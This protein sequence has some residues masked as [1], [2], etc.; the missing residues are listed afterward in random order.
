[1]SVVKS[2]NTLYSNTQ[3]C[4]PQFETSFSRQEGFQLSTL[5]ATRSGTAIRPHC[6]TDC[7]GVALTCTIDHCFVPNRP[8]QNQRENT[9]QTFKNTSTIISYGDLVTYF[10][11]KS[12]NCKRSIVQSTCIT[13]WRLKILPC[14]RDKSNALKYL[15]AAL[16]LFNP[17]ETSQSLVK[18][19]N[20]NIF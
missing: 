7:F 11:I 4:F 5:F 18:I 3:Q 17:V 12:T 10:I 19:T 8:L 2:C 1:M 20:L 9:F 6:L 13:T 16:L 15:R 14:H